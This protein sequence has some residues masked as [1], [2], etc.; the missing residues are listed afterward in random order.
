MQRTR[1][2][3]PGNKHSTY[4]EQSRYVRQTRHSMFQETAWLTRRI[5]AEK[6]F[7]R[8]NRTIMHS[9]RTRQYPSPS[10]K[11]ELIEKARY[12]FPEYHPQFVPKYKKESIPLPGGKD[13]Y[14]ER[15]FNQIPLPV[16]LIIFMVCILP[17]QACKKK[18]AAKSFVNHKRNRPLVIKLIEEKLY[19]NIQP[20][21]LSFHNTRIFFFQSLQTHPREIILYKLPSLLVT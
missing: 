18:A 17:A 6:L 21:R 1:R 12:L 14:L 9:K 10:M 8:K 5:L 3:F 7:N 2:H 16:P 20:L 13:S 15:Y 4:D 19:G 11:S